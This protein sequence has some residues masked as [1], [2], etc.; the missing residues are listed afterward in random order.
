MKGCSKNK[1]VKRLFAAA[2]GVLLFCEPELNAQ[3]QP[4]VA[5]TVRVEGLLGRLTLDQ[6]LSLLGGVDNFYTRDVP[7]IGLPRFRMADGPLGVRNWG[8]S[9]AYSAGI[10]LAATWDSALAERVGESIGDDARARG[11]HFL[12]GPGV[13][14]YRSP[15]NGRNME[16]FGEDPWLTSRM[17]VAYIDGLQS[18]GVSATV[19]HFAANNSEFDRHRSNSIVSAAALHELYLPAFEAAVKEAHVGAVMNS[20]NLVDGEHATQNRRLNLEILKGQ[21]GFQGLL[22]SDWE[23]TY[24]AVAAANAGL[25]LEM[26]GPRYMNAAN[27]NPAIAS[28]LITQAT[29]DDKVR[30]LLRTAVRFGW[31][32]RDQTQVDLPRFSPASNAVALEEAEESITLLK[33]DGHALPLDASRSVT[34]VI[35]GPD[36]SPAVTGGGGSSHVEP[37]FST[38]VLQGITDLR[39]G[40]DRIFYLPGLPR[41]EQLFAETKFD[42]GSLKIYDGDQVTTGA[43]P[44]K[45]ATTL[46]HWRAGNDYGDDP[47]ARNE[48]G[49]TY[50]WT[51]E[52]KPKT[53]GEY[54][55]VTAAGDGDRIVLRA[56]GLPVLTHVAHEEGHSASPEFVPLMLTA[57]KPVSVEVRLFTR[58]SRPHLGLGL[59]AA[60]ALL[61]PAE[62]A[63]IQ[64]ADAAIVAVGFNADYESEGYDRTFAL[65]WGQDALIGQVAALNR[66]TIVS[67]QAGGAVDAHRW[68]DKVPA[69]VMDWYGGQ[70]AGAALAKVLFGSSPSGKLP[71]SWERLAE[72]NPT[73]SHYFEEAGP[74]RRIVYAEGLYVGYR[75]YTSTKHEPLF[76]FGF[77][78]SYTSFS[79]SNLRLMPAADSGQKVTVELDVENT[80]KA[81]GAEV[82]QVYVGDPSASQTRPVKELKAFARVPLAPGAKQHLRFQLDK[83]AFSYWDTASSSWRMDAGRFEIT[84]GA[85]SVDDRLSAPINLKP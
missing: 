44:A 19:K 39:A 24:D 59:R 27:L 51:L 62:R 2:V 11:V 71:I 26:P 84:V 83:R 63:L 67:I 17:T 28:G 56:D 69:I 15:L 25:D 38:S 34:I 85:S 1:T 78:L 73:Y 8:Q 5:E 43:S 47:P 40:R 76:P 36:A 80:G 31:L 65:P 75:Y 74:G 52:V 42:S 45:P 20:Y 12:L 64:S 32:D 10:A 23:S 66:R 57:G 30:R 13:N 9:T 61:S 55:L 41:A 18:R 54:L 4:S 60:D 49:H 50:L 6:K 3:T 68:V 81:S 72:D 77:G 70:S 53:S 58:A 22:M 82:V 7:S 16:Y 21:W 48:S 14:L 46:D 33:N 37:F 79:M 29:V 35:L